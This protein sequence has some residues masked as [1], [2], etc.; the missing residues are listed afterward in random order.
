MSVFTSLWLTGASLA[1]IILLPFYITFITFRHFIVGPSHPA[2]GW[3]TELSCSCGRLWF[4]MVSAPDAPLI[5]P[6]EPKRGGPDWSKDSWRTRHLTHW[7]MGQGTRVDPV[8][9]SAAPGKYLM[10]TA[11]H[12]NDVVHAVEVP[13]FWVSRS[14]DGPPVG[15]AAEGQKVILYWPGGGV[16]VRFRLSQVQ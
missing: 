16:H 1:L 8:R 6:K 12:A 11:A 9:L 5:P 15:R 4:Q 7:I 3:L 10:G 2:W 13:A 14:D